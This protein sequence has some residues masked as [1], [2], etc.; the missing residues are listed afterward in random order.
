MSMN[1]TDNH[2]L[3]RSLHTYLLW[4]T[5]GEV[6]KNNICGYEFNE[7]DPFIIFEGEKNKEDRGE[8]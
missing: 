6:L 8:F 3:F 2:E 4:R 1:H 5:P 7:R